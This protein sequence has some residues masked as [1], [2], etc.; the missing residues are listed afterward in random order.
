MSDDLFSWK[1][2]GGCELT[3]WSGGGRDWEKVWV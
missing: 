2:E 1:G 3:G